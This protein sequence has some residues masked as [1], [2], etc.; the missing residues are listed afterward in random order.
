MVE[1]RLKHESKQIYIFENMLY[2][3]IKIGMSDNPNKR[4]TTV[5]NAA[6]FPL[7]LVY[8]S[9]PILR[10]KITENLIHKRLKDF[11]TKGEWFNIPVKVAIEHID[12][13]V[14]EAETG[15]Y[16]DLTENYQLARDCVEVYDYLI[17]N[18]LTSFH[19]EPVN[20]YQEIE[21][22]IYQDRYYNYYILYSQG[23]LFRTAKFCNY[24]LAKKFKKDHP[25]RLV[26]I[27]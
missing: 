19:G 3:I 27:E 14:K 15:E 10:P 6:G 22:F 13:A 5:E 12:A 18:T 4:L 16:K 2:P 23:K 21:D 26:E 20:I 11:R 8:E 7:K 17:K 25:E 1:D 9:E 24:N